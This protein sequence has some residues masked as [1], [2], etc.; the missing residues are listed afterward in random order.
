MIGTGSAGSAG[1]LRGLGAKPVAYGNGLAD[2]ARALAPDGFTAAL[3]LH[4]T[5]TVQA[6]RELGVSDQRIC[7][8][9]AQVDGVVVIDL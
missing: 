9:A 7:T 4:G 2:R 3:D 1:F 8:I 6:A 5:E